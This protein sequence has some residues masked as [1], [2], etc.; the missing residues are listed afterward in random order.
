MH[1][2]PHRL[3]RVL[4][5][6]LAASARVLDHWSHLAAQ[7]LPAAPVDV[8]GDPGGPP[9][10]WL[11]KVSDGRPPAH[12]L[13]YIAARAPHLLEEGGML[14]ASVEQIPHS[15]TAGNIAPTVPPHPLA[16]PTHPADDDQA[17]AMPPTELTQPM[18]GA[19][20]TQP[21][22][23]RAAPLPL[24][25]TPA[26]APAAPPIPVRRADTEA[27]PLR[28]RP[29][30]VAQFHPVAPATAPAEP[31][32]SHAPHEEPAPQ[33]H[34]T[35][36]QAPLVAAAAGPKHTTYTAPDYVQHDPVTP[37]H[38]RFTP[39]DAQ[40]VKMPAPALPQLPEMPAPPPAYPMP[41]LPPSLGRP[42]RTDSPQP[43]AQA[44]VNR[45][46]T[47]PARPLAPESPPSRLR[48]VDEAPVSPAPVLRGHDWPEFAPT[49]REPRRD[50]PGV[51]AQPIVE[52]PD[53]RWPKLP[54]SPHDAPTHLQ[55]GDP[56]HWRAWQRRVQLDQ[57]QK[58][59]LWSE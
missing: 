12:W 38:A 3:W 44:W 51:A 6:G 31:Q 48:P 20:P 16:A 18:P 2:M 23:R 27:T 56:S 22:T 40:P 10:H 29:A 41:S 4:A 52:P 5:Q 42:T 39:F 49:Q 13:A 35:R 14:A 28:L 26:Y 45:R 32:P 50:R 33:P 46:A 54:E 34:A 11:E 25:P 8:P 36:E 58:G 57:E 15:T 59:Q 21:V 53:D 1:V 43:N 17:S 37:I 30:P 7:R 24:R 19:A 55:P 9:Q 47:P